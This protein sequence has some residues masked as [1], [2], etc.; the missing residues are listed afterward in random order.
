M[1]GE[2]SQKE[3][4][5]SHMFYLIHSNNTLKITSKI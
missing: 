3:K 4:A 2:I 1:L 5:K